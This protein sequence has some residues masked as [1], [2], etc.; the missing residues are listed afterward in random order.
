VVQ[1]WNLINSAFE[2]LPGVVVE[3]SRSVD[4]PGERF[5]IFVDGGDSKEVRRN[6]ERFLA[7]ISDTI[8]HRFPHKGD[9]IFFKDHVPSH[10]LSK[11]KERES[12]THPESFHADHD[13]VEKICRFLAL[14]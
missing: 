14:R 2:T 7:S 6:R 11:D 9:K 3:G 12:C 5:V 13:L 4:L 1:T 8:L 10:I